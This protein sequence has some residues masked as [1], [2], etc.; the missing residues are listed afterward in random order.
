MKMV[1]KEFS[2]LIRDSNNTNQKHAKAYDV[3]AEQLGNL[4][5]IKT[6][7]AKTLEKTHTV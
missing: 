4:T 7:I 2:E 6:V 1:K 3:D 5:P